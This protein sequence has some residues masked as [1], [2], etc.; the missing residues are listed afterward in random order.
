MGLIKLPKYY[1]YTGDDRPPYNFHV[2]PATISDYISKGT[3]VYR[4][5]NF[6]RPDIQCK[7]LDNPEN[8]SVHFHSNSEGL[9]AEYT[10]DSGYSVVGSRTRQC[11]QKSWSGTVPT[12]DGICTYYN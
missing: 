7:P 1:F 3:Y 8:G 4:L 9:Y 2:T 11:I 10:C 5:D 6:Q 12:C